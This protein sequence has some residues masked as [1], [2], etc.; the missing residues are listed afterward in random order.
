MGRHKCQSLFAAA[1]IALAGHAADPPD[2]PQGFTLSDSLWFS[3]V[4]ETLKCDSLRFDGRPL[5]YVATI[6]RAG[7]NLVLQ[8]CKR[9]GDRRGRRDGIDWVQ[10]WARGW[11]LVQPGGDPT[12]IELE[13]IDVFSNPQPCG[14]RLAYWAHGDPSKPEDESLVYIGD[15]LTH[16][17]LARKNLRGT[18]LGT[19]D[20]FDLPT[21][22][23]NEDCTEARFDD[24]RYFDEPATLRLESP[25]AG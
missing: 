3:E 12:L 9:S 2:L 7:D 8:V 20:M 13:G 19:D 16:E 17:I 4:V 24:P 21:P 11:F 22:Q 1:V 5:G 10:G 15:L 25:A 18:W 6:R 23:W 14:N